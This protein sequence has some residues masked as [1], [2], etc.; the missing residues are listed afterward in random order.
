MHSTWHAKTAGSVPHLKTPWAVGTREVDEKR[1]V[2]LPI[3][4]AVS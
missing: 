1:D 3:P 2:L 4:Q